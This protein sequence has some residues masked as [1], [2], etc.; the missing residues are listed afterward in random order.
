MAIMQGD[1]YSLSFTLK[2][3]SGAYVTPQDVTTLELTIGNVTKYYPDEITF[4]DNTWYF[5][6]SQAETFGLNA[7]PQDAQIR[8]KLRNNIIIGVDIGKIN[9]I[10]SIS[11]EVI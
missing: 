4:N 3:S 8:V 9:I 1:S 11:K 5:P 2:D 10:E 6:I 7:S